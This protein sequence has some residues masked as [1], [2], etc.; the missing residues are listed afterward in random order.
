[1]LVRFAGR[2]TTSLFQPS[3]SKVKALI[4]TVV[5]AWVVVAG[6][7]LW[8]Q[9]VAFQGLITT[10]V[11][12]GSGCAG[13]TDSV[14]D[15][16]AA[17]SAQLYGPQG[18]TEDSA[19]NLYIADT[20]DQRI[21]KVTP[22]GTITTVAG[23]GT[24]GYNGDNIAATTAR[25]NYPT[26]V[27]VDGVGNLY[28][29]DSNNNRIRQVTPGGTITTVAG[30]GTAG[31]NGDN[32]AATTAQLNYPAGVTV[33]GAGNVYIVD[34][35]NYRIRKVTPGGTITTVA[36]TGTAGY[37][38]DNIAATS[39]E[40]YAPAGVA[41]NN[42]GDLYIA[43]TRNQRIRMVTTSGIITT[44]VGDGTAGYNGDNIPAT[45]AE[46]NYP[47][48]VAVDGA[49]NVYIADTH[50]Q[51]IRMVTTSG[52]ITT[53]AG[54]GTAGYN[55]DNIAATSAQLDLPTAT[56]LDNLGN[57]YIVDSAN[58]RIRK[59]QT[60]SVD[61]GSVNL[62]SSSP[63]LP[64]VLSFTATAQVGSV[65]VLTQGASGKD[66]QPAAGTTCTAGGYSSGSSCTVNVTFT[67]LAPGMRSGAVVLYDTATRAN[68][69]ATVYLSGTGVGSA[70][71]FGP[72]IIS[73]Q[74]GNGTEGFNGDN[75]AATSAELR[76]TYGVAM[77]GA[78]NLYIAD[79]D[80][81]RVR[82]VTPGGI[83]TTA[84][85]TGTPGFNGDNI[86]ATSAQLN[87]PW[88]VAV[89]GAGNLYIADRN[90]D[91]IRKVTPGGIITTVA[92]TG[93]SGYN[94][95]NIAATS[96]QLFDPY[97][98]AVDRSGNLYIADTANNR[99]RKVTPSGIITTAA[100]T[101]T[102]G[103]NG[104]NIAA[105]SAELYSPYGVAVDGAGNLYIADLNNWRVRKV[106]LGG[107]ITT[108]AGTGTLGYNGDNIAATSAELNYP[109]AVAVDGAGNLY[110]ADATNNRIRKVAPNGIITTVAGTG[111]PGYNGDNI[112]AT[113]VQLN[114][115]WG[116]AVDGA[117]NLYI[118]DSTNFRIRKVDVSDPPALTFPS[119]NVS[120][121]SAAQDVIIENLGNTQLDVTGISTAA[122][123][124][125]QGADTSCS[126]NGQL[127]DAAAS[128]IL[129]IE[130]APQTTGAISGSIAL[131]D[132]TLNVNG[133]AQQIQLS[134]A[135]QQTTDATSTIALVQ[136]NSA[137]GSGVTSL[138]AAFGAPN[139]AGNLIIAVVRMSTTTQTVTVTDNAGNTYTDAVSQAQ[140]SD[141]HQIHLF[142]ASNIVGGSNRVT[143]T[144]SASNNHP[145]LAVY[146]YQG[147]RAA[148]P[149]DQTAQAQGSSATPSSGATMSTA[150]AN[151]LVFAATGLPSSYT[152]TLT[153]GS[154]YTLLQQNT[155]T[156]RAA[157]EGQSV[158]ATGA[159]AGGFSLS[160][161][162]NWSAVL[163]TFAAAAGT[164]TISTSALPGGTQFVAYSATLQAS[165]GQP[166]YRWSIFTGSLPAGLQLNASTGA[167]TGTPPIGTGTSTFTVQVTDA[168]SGT[169]SK[170]LSITIGDGSGM[171]LVQAGSVEGSGVTSVSQSFA[172]ANTAGNL[173]IAFVR[174][175]T[176][177]QT[178]SVTDT[179]GN[180]YTDAV[181]QVQTSD[182]HQIHIFYTSNI[183]AGANTVTATFS[184]SNNHP[185]LAIYE[186]YGITAVDRTAAAQGNDGAPTSGL[187]AAT[188]AAN[189]LVF[190]GLGLPSSSSVTV[191]AG[192]GYKM[193]QQDTKPGGSRSATEDL[194]A[195]STGS[196]SGTL[197]LSGSAAWSCIV[198]TFK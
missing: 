26:G 14:G 37:N 150:T 196:F 110:I 107:T 108:V 31:Y 166:P 159:Y 193:E 24:A 25:L 39:A 10:A 160:S 131:T 169:A 65:G 117:G 137:T 18:L 146:E 77:D 133:A 93:T 163:A 48:G 76:Y 98:L 162:A 52:I 22:G 192:L 135:G 70:I 186:Y 174:M 74:A 134:G 62:R 66:F 145:W 85:G 8:A 71:G 1:M 101:G 177:S 97:G 40:L 183:K 54:A 191:T 55:G 81:S 156:S 129:G 7:P 44:L 64:I 5:C 178:V 89:D 82:K 57:F 180:V 198:A 158:T 16:C 149:L 190:A 63:A 118:A 83:I 23:T 182:G 175:S 197:T 87:D 125:L 151:E 30:T 187:T 173:I 170:D 181:N 155:T 56:L 154:G 6:G 94:G 49:G 50:N 167:I 143:A 106:T 136:S 194:T 79:A 141:G 90:N 15:G 59:V 188:T 19:G 27:A 179:A 60:S 157:S 13:Q 11:G 47:G 104:D 103:Y 88:G 113:S 35:D 51:R 165:G 21:R 29:A 119:T 116:V 53:L 72:G 58:S 100:G 99:I 4:V 195:T 20:Y 3:I 28:I 80:N 161:S 61:F 132:N 184:G 33:D 124:T 127:L 102:Y 112:A 41:V 67:P 122:N 96:A 73:T 36:G 120:S 84:A 43:D 128:C 152:G 140:S 171:A 176:A 185:F 12:G 46:L 142:Y 123:F 38:G 111:T 9:S 75:I 95:D 78:G 168:N 126:S 32:I 115:P 92:G 69:L 172:A 42:A 114:Y 153:A 17:S 138:A 91:R 144:F 68:A 139:T 109:W 147:L 34:A 121:V 105:T 2:I 148:S 130:F 164:P 189:E 86:A 45:S